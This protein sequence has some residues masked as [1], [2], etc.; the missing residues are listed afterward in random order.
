[1]SAQERERHIVSGAIRFFSENGLNAQMRDLAK[2]MGVTHTLVY[3]YF[4]TKQEL[5][6]RVFE[7]V[8]AGRWDPRWEVLL[9]DPG[10]AVEDKLVTF[11]V[12]YARI[13]LTRDFVRILLF[14]GLTDQSIP[15]R[16]FP[17]LAQRLFPRLIRESRRWRGVTS[18]ARPSAREHEL[19]MGLH[20]GIFYG[21]LRRYVYVHALHADNPAFDDPAVIRDRVRGYLAASRSLAP[22]PTLPPDMTTSKIR[23]RRPIRR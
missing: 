8:F 11:Y 12:E 13:V 16:L 22:Q 19:L 5:V 17:L 14:S 1:M 15:D 6:D 4:K 2:A 23:V 21:G 9:D 20:G 3:H 7:E 10:L 18:R